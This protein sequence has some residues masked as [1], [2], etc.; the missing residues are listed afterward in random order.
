MV[1]PW[2]R[3]NLSLLGTLNIF[4]ELSLYLYLC[5]AETLISKVNFI[6]AQL[7]RQ[8]VLGRKGRLSYTTDESIN[9]CNTILQGSFIILI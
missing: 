5:N 3:E 4:K 8:C 6:N 7:S 2:R 1:L 9:L